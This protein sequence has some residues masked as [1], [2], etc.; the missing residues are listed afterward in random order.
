MTQ[1]DLIKWFEELIQK[2]ESVPARGEWYRETQ[3]AMAWLSE[4]ESALA[5]AFPP[6]HAVRS[7]WKSIQENMNRPRPESWSGWRYGADAN[8]V[9]HG[10]GPFLQ[11]RGVVDTALALLNSG[12]LAS[13][14]DAVRAETVT[15]LLNQA[16]MLL[17][18]KYTVAATVLAGGALE[19][20]LLHLCNRS[21]LTW[22]RDGSIEKYNR[23]IG[24][25]RNAKTVEVY[26][27]SDSKL[28]TG[29]GGLR[30]NAAHDPIN[31][32][33]TPQEVGLMIESIRQFSARV[34]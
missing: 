11:A 7:R 26:S 30:N 15:D 33:L 10:N 1:A 13:V 18:G 29:W 32:R 27:A 17:A 8:T 19:T 20:H 9:P 6:S 28:V 24:E 21:G 22:D 2:G 25:A 14:L 16:A 31:F 23:A 3:P 34:P 4:A 12:R 5:S